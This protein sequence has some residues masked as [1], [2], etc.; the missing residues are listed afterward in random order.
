[1]IKILKALFITGSFTVAIAGAQEITIVD[2]DDGKPLPDVAIMLEDGKFLT[3]TSQSGIVDISEFND[4]QT[5]CFHLVSFER[6]CVTAGEIRNSGNIIELKKRVF[7]IE[8]FVVSASRREQ[9]K[10]ETPGRIAVVTDRLIKFHNPQTAADLIASS[11]EVFVQKS[12]LGGGSPMIRGF[13]TN[14]VL[15][16]VDGVRMNNAI[17]R[18][19]NIQNVISL[20]PNVIESAEI[21]FGPG[22]IVY[23]SDAIGGVMDFHT[24]K[25]MLSSFNK[26]LF[27]AGAMIRYSSA[28]N[29]KS[30]QI[31]INGGF[32][33]AGFYGAISYSS[34]DDLRMGSHKHPE[35]I[36]PEYAMYINKKDTIIK[37][38]N[39]DVQIPS[40]YSQLNTT[41]KFRYRFSNNLD[42]VFSNHFSALSNVPRYDRLIQ[43]KSGTL[44]YGEWYYGPQVWMMNNL[45]VSYSSPNILFNHLKLTAAYQNYRES[46][47]D[48][49][50]GKYNINEQFEKVKIF[51]L[52][53]DFD[54][55]SSSGKSLL[56]YGLEL[57]TNNIKSEAWLRNILTVETTPAGSRYPN[58]K[59]RY[60]SYSAYAGYRINLS[61]RTIFSSG[62]RYNYVTLNSTIADNS[63][64]NFPFTRIDI[65]N[66]A[67][68]GS[69]GIVI[70]PGQK[71]CLSINASTGFRAPNLDDAGK[72]FDS[73]PGIVVVPNPD[74]KPEYAYNI[75]AEI[76][77]DFGKFLHFEFSGFF[78]WLNNAMVR[79]DF[80]FNG[81]DSIMYQG[82]LSKVEAIVNASYARVYGFSANVYLNI[83]RHFYLK[84]VLNVTE[85]REKGNIPLRH[86]APLFGSTHLIFE[87]QSL[88][89]DLYSVYNGPKKFSDM[90][91]SEREKPYIYATDINGN[92]WSPGWFTINFKI[93]YTIPGIVLLSA[94]CE[95]ILD[96]RY[97]P[98]SWGIVAPG[99]NF[100]LSLRVTL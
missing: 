92:P 91:P 88:K 6:L 57:V 46:R 5:I 81:E 26:P 85:G 65:S 56:Y 23:G 52:N 21:I 33:K 25:V 20:D 18:E 16:V 11:D 31:K 49:A 96:Y 100:I 37:N 70:R 44:R 66:G 58:G 14:R 64:Y 2:A 8:E 55:K 80:L 68:T 3:Y 22:S 84:S 61:D 67:L 50:F 73:A 45:Q 1:M 86:S 95:N 38:S 28:N 93:S 60:N 13:A 43:Y 48:R 51:S 94:G 59:N 71:T 63:F 89:A 40:G 69:A 87:N 54:R 79:H 19:G 72:V 17:Y 30:S 9:R 53:L 41:G 4:N 35:Y 97:R 47:H 78:T 98:Y 74:L 27:K 24:D 15:I 62:L 36:R 12:Q 99:R 10:S 82:Q 32:K 42:V 75:D 76:E 7:E 83:M 34:F 29:E 90:P 77:K 39:P